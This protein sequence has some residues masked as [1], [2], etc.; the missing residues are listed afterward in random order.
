M[1]LG[2]AEGMPVDVAVADVSE[3]A[4]MMFVG[5]IWAVRVLVP[6][7]LMDIGAEEVEDG[8]TRSGWRVSGV[9]LFETPV[10]GRRRVGVEDGFPSEVVME[11]EPNLPASEDDDSV[12]E[13]AEVACELSEDAD[14]VPEPPEEL[15][16]VEL[17]PVLSELCT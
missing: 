16:V 17:L 15:A 10:V 3:V 5:T 2:S 8:R 1:I 4:D 9:V 14:V 12:S 11:V 7:G 6:V 13:V